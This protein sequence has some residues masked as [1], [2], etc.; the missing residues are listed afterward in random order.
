MKKSPEEKHPF[1]Y[2]R[3]HLTR[4][5]THSKNILE[6]KIEF[7]VAYRNKVDLGSDQGALHG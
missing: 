3:I 5:P 1:I 2:F 4:S 7:I 6:L